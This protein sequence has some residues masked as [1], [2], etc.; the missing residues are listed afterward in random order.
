M[1]L[2]VT[3]AALGIF[4]VIVCNSG[5]ETLKLLISGVLERE[6]LNTGVL[7]LVIRSLDVLAIDELFADVFELDINCPKLLNTH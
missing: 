6:V 7:D 5:S 1:Q 2:V 4:T 3:F